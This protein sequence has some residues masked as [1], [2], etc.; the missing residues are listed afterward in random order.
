MKKV[1]IGL[2][3]MALVGTASAQVAKQSTRDVVNKFKNISEVPQKTSISNA[4]TVT[5]WSNDF[6]TSSDWTITNAGASG[7]PPHTAGDWT[8]T[9]DLSASPVSALN[10]AGF[11]T[12]SN[13]YA[14][15]SSDA[16]GDGETQNATIYMASSIDLSASPNVSLVFSQT[17]RRYMESTYV[18]VSND[19]GVTWTDFEVNGNMVTNTNSAN[20]E[21]VQVNISSAAGGYS[22]VKIGFKYVGAYDWF[23]AVDDVNINQ[24]EDYDLTLVGYYWGVEGPWGARLP[25]YKT[26]VAQISAIKFGGI[27]QNIGALTQ[28]DVTFGAAI[29]SASYASTSSVGTLAPN[30]LDTLDATV[31]FT[32][33]AAVATFNLVGTVASSATDAAPSNNTN[34]ALSFATDNFIYQRDNG[35]M[36]SGS[37]NQGQGFEVGSIYDIM[38]DATLYSVNVMVHP[39]ANVGAEMYA[40]VYTIDSGTGD[41]VYAEGSEVHPISSADLGAEVNLPLLASFD[42]TANTSYLV[43][44]GSYGDGGATDDLVVGTGGVSEAQTSFYFDMTDQIWYYTT[45]GPMVRLSFED[46]TGLAENNAFDLNVFPN[47]AVDG[48]SVAFNLTSASDVSVAVVDLAGKTVYTSR[49]VNAAAGKHAVAINTTEMAA[50]VYTVNFTANNTV[51]TKKFVVKK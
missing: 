9:T 6:S 10:P 40:T 50:G 45:S 4:K 43:V 31:D 26:P 37:Y 20:P 33:A 39:N 28:S 38:A 24:T 32:P 46:N 47:P 41:F 8:I 22:Q 35:T 5:L 7:T 49:V 27:C 1:Y 51:I 23:W 34:S 16:A 15:I 42:M 17:H 48:A 3:A 29:A 36:T 11:T 2:F 21:Q 19:N 12:G 30:G 44:V 18:I 13:G 25:Y 14:F